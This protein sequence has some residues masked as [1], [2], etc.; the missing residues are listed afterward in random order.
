MQLRMGPRNPSESMKCWALFFSLNLSKSGA[1]KQEKEEPS[2]NQ[3]AGISGFRQLGSS[4]PSRKH[5][6][7]FKISST[8]DCE[9]PKHPDKVGTSHGLPGRLG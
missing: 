4:F 5:N 3:P 6:E 8:P 2:L 9:N 7:A 1:Q